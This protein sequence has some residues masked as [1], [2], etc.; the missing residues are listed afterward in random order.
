MAVS[1]ALVNFIEVEKLEIEGKEMLLP[2]R[3][4]KRQISI[5]SWAIGSVANILE[6]L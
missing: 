3:P 1:I 4:S 6:A 2:R 5:G